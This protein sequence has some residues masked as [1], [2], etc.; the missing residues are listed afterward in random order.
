MSDKQIGLAGG[1]PDDKKLVARLKEAREYMGISQ[2]KVATY[3]GVPRSAVSE[4][5]SGKRSVSALELQRLAKLYHIARFDKPGG[6]GG[7]FGKRNSIHLTHL[8]KPLEHGQLPCVYFQ[9]EPPGFCNKRVPENVIQVT[10]RID[11]AHRTQVF[12]P[13]KIL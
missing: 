10:V 9:S 5:E 4:I 1:A 13:D 12:L 2:E 3:L 8:W 11:E 7:C 6:H